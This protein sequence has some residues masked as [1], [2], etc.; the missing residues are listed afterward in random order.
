MADVGEEKALVDDILIEGGVGGALIEVSFPPHVR[1]AT[2]LLVVISFLVHLIFPFL[3]VVTVT[4][5]WTFSYKVTRL[6]TPVAQLSWNGVCSP[7][8][9]FASGFIESA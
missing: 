9:S 4:C 7:S 8:P 5:I 2:L 6:T 1:L 3:V